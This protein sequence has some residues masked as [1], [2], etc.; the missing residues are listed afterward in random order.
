MQKI[1]PTIIWLLVSCSMGFLGLFIGLSSSLDKDAACSTHVSKWSS[2]TK[3]VP[4]K[5]ST[6][7]FNGNFMNENIYRKPANPETDQAWEDLGVNYRPLR[8]PFEDGE[9][10]GLTEKNVHINDNYGGGFPANVEGLH[11]LHCLNLLRQSL[12][13]NYAYYKAQ[14]KGAFVNSDMV[15]QLHVSHCVDILRQQLM[16]S[17]DTGVLGQVWWN[18]TSPQ[19]FVDFNTRHQCKNFEAVRQWAEQHQL[20]ERPPRGFLAPPIEGTVL[21]SMP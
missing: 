19:A 12:Y 7:Q 17:V 8:I 13:Y 2:V 14:G 10:A 4:I 16:C 9:K 21:E 20:P 11:H 3:D 15:V 5:W 1:L 18:Q 6:I